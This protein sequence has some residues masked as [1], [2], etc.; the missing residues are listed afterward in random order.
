MEGLESRER[1][2]GWGVAVVEVWGG[3]T[4]Q[5]IALS[6]I[7]GRGSGPPA[8]LPGN[9]SLSLFCTVLTP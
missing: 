6:R 4:L 2:T 7:S 8:P 5:R 1:R 3:D 9:F